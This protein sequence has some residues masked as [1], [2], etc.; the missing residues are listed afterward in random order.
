MRPCLRSRYV[1][2]AVLIVTTFGRLNADEPPV[3][4]Q[5]VEPKPLAEKTIKGL[6]YLISQ[7]HENGGWGQGGGW[8]QGAKGGGR[9]EGKEVA[10]PP[11]LGNTCISALALIRAG[12]TPTEGLYAK[13]LARA[14]DFI[15]KHVEASDKESLYV[16]DVR[17]TQLQSKIG[18]YVDTFLAGLVLSELK[19][20]ACDKPLEDRMAGALEKTIAKIER[21]QKQDGTFAENAG[22]ASVL[23]QGLCSKA[24][25]RAFQN[26]VSVKQETLDR[27]LNVAVNGLAASAAKPALTLSGS[28]TVAAGTVISGATLTAGAGGVAIGGPAPADPKVP[29][30]SPVT[31]VPS[32]AGVQLYAFS[33]NNATAAENV[34]SNVKLEEKAREVLEDSA[35]SPAEKEQATKD[36]RR[37]ADVAKVQEAA[38][39]GILA[40][41]D[42]KQFIAGFGNNGGEEFL[43]YMNISETLLSKGGKEWEKWDRE[44]SANLHRVQNQDSSWS[45]HHCITGRTFCSATALLTLMADRAPTPLAQK[46]REGK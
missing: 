18:R 3:T 2:I 43:S 10:D 22:W 32:D 12:N 30:A 4:K 21:N 42:D 39:E 15:C 6:E 44:I 33:A 23:S 11:D 29:V 25:N 27:D 17:D 7:Q 38:R 8:R 19:G 46:I 41:L 36:L 16:T 26:G 14:V 13:Q 31:A 5:P 37:V 34:T 28:A 45:G 40:R 20:K 24:L 9:V 1:F 35:A